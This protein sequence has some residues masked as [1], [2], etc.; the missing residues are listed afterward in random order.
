MLRSK[1]VLI[2]LVATLAPLVLTL[3]VTASLLDRSLGYAA[4]GQTKLDEVSQSLEKT[5][6]EFYQRA[7][8]S[9]KAGAD[10]GTIAPLRTKPDAPQVRE[11]WESGE[12]DRFALSGAAGDRLDYLVR[13]DN[14]VWIY[15][16][17]LEIGMRDLSTQITDARE[18]V[19][20]W[21]THDL[22]RGFVY[23]YALVA[24]GIWLSSFALLVFLA[25]RISRPIQQLT[26]ALSKL[27]AGDPGVRVPTGRG[28][29]I[30]R[31][32]QAFNHMADQLQ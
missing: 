1:L 27:A 6:K 12:P 23:T 18:S 8:A 9:L 17:P 32:I 3:W 28:D 2:F 7:R 16:A 5:G 25:S 29:E 21:K 22:K 30:G 15:S 31:A 4:E 14:E 10:A 11:F 13:R 20:T 26:A 24:I 19:D